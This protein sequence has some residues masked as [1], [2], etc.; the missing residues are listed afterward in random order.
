MCT[1]VFACSLGSITLLGLPW[2][3]I[4]KTDILCWPACRF[5]ADQFLAGYNGYSGSDEPSIGL[6]YDGRIFQS[7]HLNRECGRG[8]W[9]M[10]TTT[11]LFQVLQT[12]VHFLISTCA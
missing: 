6:D 12:V 4:L 2:S 5:W 9:G 8:C 3:C 7:L 1:C 10:N 11:G